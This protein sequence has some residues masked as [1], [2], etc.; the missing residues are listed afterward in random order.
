VN[1]NH[2]RKA[3]PGSVLGL[4]LVVALAGVMMFALAIHRASHS[5]FSKA[6]VAFLMGVVAW[7]IVGRLHAAWLSLRD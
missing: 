5:A 1:E 4:A 2:R 6:S 3:K 7:I